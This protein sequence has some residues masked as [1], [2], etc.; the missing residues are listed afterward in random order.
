MLSERDARVALDLA[1]LAV[2][3]GDIAWLRVRL[4]PDGDPDLDTAK[5]EL[6][7]AAE[8]SRKATAAAAELAPSDPAVIRARI[9]TLRLSGDVV[10][11]RR[12]VASISAASG[13]ADNALAL[14]ELDVGEAKP[15]W[16]TVI[17]R[18]RVALSG[19]QNLGR[20]RAMLIY[21]LARSGD[22]PTAK[23]EL[24]RM[25][26]LPR[27]HALVRPLR[28]F[29]SREGGGAPA[30]PEPS[31]SA[32]AGKQP[33]GKAPGARDRSFEPSDPT[34]RPRDETPPPTPPREATSTR[35]IS[36]ESSPSRLP[37]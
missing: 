22:V 10:G 2:V 28:A 13:Q 36:L 5:R 19:D 30:V 20:A 29:V 33:P 27:P 11:A 31:G 1:H 23:A 18:L 21:A 24:E 3:R 35:R 8:R 9:D 17:G 34:P 14:A 12:L 32:A 26:A 16:P 15:D 6:D 37:R 25:I 7:Q 4:L